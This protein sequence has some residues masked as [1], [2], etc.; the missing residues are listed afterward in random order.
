MVCDCERLRACSQAA[1]A[2]ELA[3]VRETYLTSAIESAFR[4][5]LTSERPRMEV[6]AT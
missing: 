5:G 3:Y 2:D 4:D 6:I 1:G